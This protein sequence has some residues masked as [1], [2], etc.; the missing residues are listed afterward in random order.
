LNTASDPAGPATKAQASLATL[1][2]GVRHAFALDL[3][4][5]LR[6]GGHDREQH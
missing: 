4:F 3:V 5:H 6:E 2:D 1:V